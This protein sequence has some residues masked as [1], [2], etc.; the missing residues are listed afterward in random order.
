[1]DKDSFSL[2][3]LFNAFGYLRWAQ[4][5]PF[6]R[7]LK[8]MLAT[9]AIN[10]GVIVL[11]EQIQMCDPMHNGEVSTEAVFETIE[12]ENPGYVKPTIYEIISYL[13]DAKLHIAKF[14][15]KYTNV[16]DPDSIGGK[17]KVAIALGE[18]IIYGS[19]F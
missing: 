15:V 5:K 9:G 1:M 10:G 11:E 8:K 18:W 6:A 17:G 19:S 4:R 14:N 16:V 7:W 12:D 2:I 3:V 13:Q